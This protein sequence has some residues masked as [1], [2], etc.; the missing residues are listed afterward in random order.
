[1]VFYRPEYRWTATYK[2]RNGTPYEIDGSDIDECPVSYISADSA[3]LAGSLELA[4]QV[5]EATGESPLPP[6]NRWPARLIDAAR[7]VS[8]ER[9]KEHNACGEAEAQERER[10]RER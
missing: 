2:T 7:L 5:R 3:E 1:V 4:R 8:I 10:E 9:I 6:V